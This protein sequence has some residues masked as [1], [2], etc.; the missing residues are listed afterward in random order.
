MIELTVL[1]PDDWPLWRDLRLRA[2][3]GSPEAFGSRLADWQGEGDREERWRG[4]LGIPGSFDLVA[5]LDGEPVGMASG[6]PA[7]RDDVVELISMW[8]APAARGAGVGDALVTEVMRRARDAGAAALRLA[9][10]DGNDPARALYE[11][12]GFRATGEL[13][14]P[15][16][17]GVRHEVVMEL[18]LGR[19]WA[20][21]SPVLQSIRPVVAAS[22]DVRTS[23]AAIEACADW[24]AYEG[25]GPPTSPFPLPWGTTTEETIDFL[26]V[27]NCIN[28]AYTDFDTGVVFQ[29]E[30]AGRSWSDSD[31]MLVSI[32]RAVEEGVPFLDGEYLASV[33]REDLERVFR[34]A[35]EMPMLDERVAIFN[36]VG[37]VLA[38][39][40]DGRF[41]RFT[42]S[43]APRLYD[44]GNGLLER[45]VAEFPRFD[46]VSRYGSARPQFFK[47][48]QLALWMTYASLHDGDRFPIEDL[49]AMTAFADYIVP[50]ALRVM[51]ILE[52]SPELEAAIEGRVEIPAGS[53]WEVEIRA[54]TLHASDLLREELN[55]RR[56]ADRQL[57]TPQ[58]DAR[59]WTHFHTTHW[60][61]HLTRT[62][63]Y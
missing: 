55:R 21:G 42:A 12:H 56:P 41:H 62:T 44:G 4:R 19:P 28:F 59:L 14:D 25:F 8:V 57:I 52:Y 26:L 6:V 45:M 47:L 50:V 43:C 7:D 15:M 49:D 1:T 34:G 27:G 61:H 40:Y 32:R 54:H 35:S 38:E 24:M 20:A 23:R 3:A 9:V 33:T 5:A 48:A 36:E 16:P 17:D 53:A 30:Y 29:T 18:S 13:G 2:L 31:A 63:M 60:P 10:A 51:G 58:V 11:R 37:R 22:R 39:S 46:D